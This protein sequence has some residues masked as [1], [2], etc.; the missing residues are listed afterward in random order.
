MVEIFGF[1]VAK[2]DVRLHARDLDGDRAREALA[3]A[4]EARARH[5]AEA[6]D[7]LI[8]SGTS[9]ID[10]IRRARELTELRVVPLFETVDDLDAAPGIVE[11][12]LSEQS[13]R[14]AEVMVG[15]SDSGKDSGYLAA[16]WAIYRAQ[17]QLAEV[18]RRHDVELT[19]FHGRGGS[20]GRGG[21]PTHAAI[22]SQPASFPPGHL[23][24]TEQG[25]TIS[26]KY[27]LE[28]L[29]RRNLEAALAGTLL[30]T[31]PERLEPPPSDDD[32]AVLDRLAAVSREAYRAFVWEDP[33]FVDFFRAFTPVD[34]SRCSRSHPDRQ[35]GRTGPTTSS[36]C[37]RSRGCSRGHRTACSS[38]RG[39]ARAARSRTQTPACCATSIRGCRSCERSSTTWR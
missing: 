2:L 9:S 11:T 17:E 35:D 26:F 31:Y 28:G 8:I 7:T 10:D 12:M 27:S 4:S 15:Y 38:R 29:A 23:K 5:G 16:Q 30:A 1:H 24:V 13:D 6:L 21:G 34:S 3:A 36:R 37:A 33:G 14:S 20:A 32:R 39:L 19:I 18:A 22:A 25:E